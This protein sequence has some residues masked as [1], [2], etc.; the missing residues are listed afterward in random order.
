MIA[1]WRSN[2]LFHAETY[3]S[4]LGLMM[5]S[6]ISLASP[7]LNL[8]MEQLKIRELSLSV[9]PRLKHLLLGLQDGNGR[10]LGLG[11]MTKLD[12]RRRTLSALTP[13]GSAGAVG[14][15]CFGRHRILPDGSDG[16]SLKP[17]DC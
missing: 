4:H 12:F 10:T 14:E 9:A 2:R 8:V 16:G 5:A 7:D 13:V 6:P 15:I 1:T 3:G 17:G 11:I